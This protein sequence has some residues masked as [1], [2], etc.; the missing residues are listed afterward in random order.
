[1]WGGEIFARGA[2]ITDKRPRGRPPGSAGR[3]KL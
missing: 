3:V 2:I 1:V